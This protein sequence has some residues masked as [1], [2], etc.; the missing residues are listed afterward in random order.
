MRKNVTHQHQRMSVESRMVKPPTATLPLTYELKR[1][2]YCELRSL[3]L[4]NLSA[5]LRG[6]PRRRFGPSLTGWFLPKGVSS[7]RG[8]GSVMIPLSSGQGCEVCAWALKWPRRTIWRCSAS[9][10]HWTAVTS[11]RTRRKDERRAII[12]RKIYKTWD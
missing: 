9:E 7:V 11:G 3:G 4:R 2:K 12:R 6:A 8:W 5:N 10:E 1:V